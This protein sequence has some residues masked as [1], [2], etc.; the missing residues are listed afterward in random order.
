MARMYAYTYKFLIQATDDAERIYSKVVGFFSKEMMVKK[1]EN[2]HI[3]DIYFDT[4][5][6]QLFKA[7]VALR[8]RQL[9][10]NATLELIVIPKRW[11]RGH[12]FKKRKSF[13]MP[14]KPDADAITTQVHD[15]IGLCLDEKVGPVAA[16][17]NERTEIALDHDGI[18]VKLKLDRCKM[19]ADFKST[20]LGTVALS[21]RMKASN[22]A[23]NDF[24]E[25]KIELE[26]SN[27]NEIP[28]AIKR[29]V[30]NMKAD[31]E[32]MASSKTKVGYFLDM[33][34]KVPAQPVFLP[35]EMQNTFLKKQLSFM[36]DDA[37][38]NELPTCINLD[39]EYF[40][41]FRVG[42]RKSRS[43][44]SNLKSLISPEAYTYYQGEWRWIMQTLGKAW[45][46]SVFLAKL[47][48]LVP[49]E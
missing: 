15:T 17:M 7:G 43:I 39:P 18:P 26:I 13:Y 19:A 34:F 48:D 41:A 37:F 30:K 44:L 2:K 20:C 21:P 45:S 38:S 23:V 22:A 25:L 36:L 4:G 1:P 24:T 27:S 12:Y 9:N 49:G 5:E 32:T 46:Q 33:A 14:G 29:L 47:M 31:D 8:E 11:D 35:G 40:H 6:L 16:L 10:N 3:V 42:L 28:K